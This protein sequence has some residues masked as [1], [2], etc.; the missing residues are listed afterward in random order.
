MRDGW[1]FRKIPQHTDM[2]VKILHLR[3]IL[4]RAFQRTYFS[5]SEAADMTDV[6][7]Y[8]EMTDKKTQGIIKLLG[9]EPMQGR[10]PLH[11]SIIRSKTHVSAL[12]DAGHNPGTLVGRIATRMTIKKC[13]EHGFGIVGVNN[14]YSSTGALGFYAQEIATKDF[15]GIV[16]A[17]TPK[18]VAPYGA[19]DKT[20]GINPMAISFPT[21]RDP[22]ILDMATA[23][24]TWY[25]LVR[26]KIMGTK[27]PP[28]VAIN[29][30]GELTVDPDEAMK[31]AILTFGNNPKMSGLA[32]M[33]E[34]FTGPL[35]DA[36]APDSSGVWYSGSL[37]IAIDPKLLIGR[38]KFKKHVTDLIRKIK[39][40]RP[41]KRVKEVF[42]P[43][44][45]AQRLLQQAKKSG[46]IEVD[47]AVYTA[48]TKLP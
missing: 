36:I 32:M 39:A 40:S 10:K 24:I 22:L 4:K 29:H 14:S 48:I 17:G 33:L 3:R 20:I 12:I 31:G 45:Q 23:A 27:L 35:V 5:A 42:L 47:D 7:L 15:I 1:H 11:K 19:I 34:M 28:G 18:A 6:L 26:S 30:A 43:G 8:A 38:K 16:M 2:N 37:F 9:N 13:R 41:D 21:D 46:R 44:E 25:G